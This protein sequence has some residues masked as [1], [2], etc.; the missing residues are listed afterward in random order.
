VG[1]GEGTRSICAAAVVFVASAALSRP[2]SGA[3]LVRLAGKVVCVSSVALAGGQLMMSVVQARR[4]IQKASDNIKLLLPQF[5][6]L[7]EQLQNTRNKIALA[8]RRLEAVTSACDAIR[9]AKP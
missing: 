3:P 9:A 1:E 8:E 5:R 4:E 6:N 2:L 7:G